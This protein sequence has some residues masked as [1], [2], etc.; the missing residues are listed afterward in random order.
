MIRL[1]K[2]NKFFNKHKKNEIHVINDTS[3]NLEG[4]GLIALLGPSGCGKTTLLN[5]IGGLDGVSNGNVILDDEKLTGKMTFKKDKIRNL[6]VGYIFQNYNLID[7]MTVFDNVALVLKMQG[8]KDKEEIKEKV[9]YALDMVGMYRYRNRYADMLSGG[10]RQ[11]VG[12]ARA[13]AK[14][15]PII[16]ADEPTGNLDSKN[17][18]E[19]MNIIKA[20][21]K[22]KLVILVTHEEKLANFYASRII[23]LVDGKVVSDEV[24]DHENNL[25]YKIDNKIYLQDLKSHKHIAEGSYDI[26][27]YDAGDSKI[28]LDIVIKNGNIYFK[29]EDQLSRLEI[30]DDHSSIELVDGH[31]EEIGKDEYLNHK[32]DIKKL[33]PKNNPKH[34]SILNSWTLIKQGFN[35]VMDYP[36]L[37]KL[38]MV[39][40]FVS[41]MFIVY[42]LS[43]IAGALNVPDSR[44]VTTNKDYLIIKNKEV[45]IEDFAKYEATPGIGYV[46]PGNSKVTMQIPYNDFLQTSAG[47]GAVQGS[48]S[49]SST[50]KKADIE[51]GKLPE[52]PYE[53]AID[54]LALKKLI[55]KGTGKQAGFFNVKDFIGKQIELPNIPKFT[56]VGITNK[57][58]PNIY[59][60]KGM[61][62][63]VLAS[64]PAK[65]DGDVDFQDTIQGGASAGAG[66]GATKLISMKMVEAKGE[67]NLKSGRWPSEDYE[68]VVNNKNREQMPLNKEIDTKVNGKKLKVVGYFTDDYDRDLQVVT[69]TTLKYSL[70][71]TKADVTVYPT[72]DKAETI[73]ALQDQGVNVYDS[74]VKAKD[75]YKKQ[76]SKTVQTAII[77]GAVILAISLI[78]IYLIVRASFLSRIKEVGVY[79]A[80]GVK[81][82][83]IYRMFLGE[84]IA[85][86]TIAG[87][88]GFAFMTYI[89]HNLT[90]I[91]MFQYSF[92][93]TPM[94]ALISLGVIYIVNIVFGLLP[95][96]GVVRKTPAAILS[97]TD[98]D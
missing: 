28:S 47:S 26:N 46:L 56:L 98:V 82:I 70:I 95:V 31:Y 51:E 18:L 93:M 15:P 49:D 44:F 89:I 52:G 74:Y 78:E 6:K 1:E 33:V 41:S 75:D 94:V 12:I 50:L 19:V 7:N 40:F 45:K 68:V 4:P 36:M 64:A 85:I 72:G 86:T 20:I 24:N 96:W 37:K 91:E 8:M 35:T 77:M 81:R 66:Q 11:R 84:I 80:I 90:S 63:D 14:N 29:T 30:V 88:P 79:R 23:R 43:N 13:I 57:E 48:L 76:T 10:E 60:D 21:S 39:G 83:D 34:S 71:T 22:E 62:I 42:S 32:F 69:D 5:V 25:D 9:H 16:I 3:L 27:L 67:L 97:R 92:V 58:Q 54:K 2:V 59:M 55:D 38:L 17:T 53:V 87:I 73:K 61:F 65:D